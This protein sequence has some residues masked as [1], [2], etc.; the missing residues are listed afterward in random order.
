MIRYL[1]PCVSFLK[2]IHRLPFAP[3]P[4]GEA[5]DYKEN[6]YNNEDPEKEPAKHPEPMVH[7]NA[8]HKTSIEIF[9]SFMV[10]IYSPKVCL[11]IC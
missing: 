3:P 9:V 10:R 1:T 4:P 8:P 7:K 2:Y 11:S 6:P 5:A